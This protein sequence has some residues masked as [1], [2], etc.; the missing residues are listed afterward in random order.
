MAEVCLT[1]VSDRCGRGVLEAIASWL[2][3]L[4][5][6]TVVLTKFIGNEC[7]VCNCL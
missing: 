3:S 6:C 2:F 7:C 4:G 5:D 1:G